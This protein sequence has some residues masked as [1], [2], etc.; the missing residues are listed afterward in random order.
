MSEG[1]TTPTINTA[2][3]VGRRTLHFDTMSDALRDAQQLATQP[4]QQLGNWS[5]GKICQHLA[6]ALDSATDDNQVD[7]P[8]LVGWVAPLFKGYLLK[9]GLRPGFQMTRSMKGVFMPPDSVTTAAGLEALATAVARFE[10][11]Q[12]PPRSKFLGKMTRDDWVAFHCRHAEL[13]L[14]FIVPVAS[15]T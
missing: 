11:A 3:V 5:L 7:P 9:H 13:H 12:L 2:K 6:Q 1:S 4:C 15:T 14:S 10:A 8:P